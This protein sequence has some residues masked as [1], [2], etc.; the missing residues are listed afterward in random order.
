MGEKATCNH[1]Y[2]LKN[3]REEQKK[4]IRNRTLNCPFPLQ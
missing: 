1:I 2:N 4:T 3:I